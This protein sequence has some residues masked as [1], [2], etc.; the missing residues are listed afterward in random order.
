MART[1]PIASDAQQMR[2]AHDPGSLARDP[3][4]GVTLSPAQEHALR[5]SAPLS[6]REFKT[7]GQLVNRGDLP[8]RH[9]LGRRHDAR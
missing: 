7:V 9:L 5:R 6:T 4:A 2:S 8:L 3:R 1:R